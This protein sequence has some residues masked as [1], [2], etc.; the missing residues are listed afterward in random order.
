MNFLQK[1]AFGLTLTATATAMTPSAQALTLTAGD[2][3]T[4]NFDG[5]SVTGS[6]QVISLD[7]WWINEAGNGGDATYNAGNGSNSR[8]NTYSFGEADHSDRAL[9]SVASGSVQPRYGVRFDVVGTSAIGQLF[10]QYDQEQWRVNNATDENV[11]FQYKIAG[12]GLLDTNAWLAEDLDLDL[13][14]VSVDNLD[15]VPT[16]TAAAGAAIDGN[17][18]ANRVVRQAL[19]AGLN[20]TSGSSLLLRWVD[21]DST[22]S[23][24]GLAIDNFSLQS[25]A[26]DVAAVPTPA[27]LPGLVAMG[28]GL[29]RKRKSANV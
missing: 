4:Q 15:L 20:V 19:I 5:L 11:A 28:L 12:P 13:G 9:G 27:L 8:G 24:F 18:A 25:S 16:S 10:L 22:G 7:G 3:Y 26:A 6:G 14:W 2:T 17:A 1:L 21:T 29:L 23:D